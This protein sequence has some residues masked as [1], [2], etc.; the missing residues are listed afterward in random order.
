VN[1]IFNPEQTATFYDRPAET[2]RSINAANRNTNYSVVRPE[3]LDRI[4]N[5]L[6]HQR[7]RHESEHHW[8]HR[9]LPHRAVLAVA[10]PSSDTVRLELQRTP[11]SEP[12]RETVEYDLVVLATGYRHNGH[13]ELLAPL[14]KS[15]AATAERS[16]G[17]R[18]TVGKDYRLHVAGV[19]VSPDAGIWLQGCNEE[20]HGVSLPMT[21]W[22]FFEMRAKD[23]C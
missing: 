4:Y 17:E 2:R 23:G 6:Y 10:A 14:L 5:T 13:E 3:L 19:D 21:F 16:D 22:L 11:R 15:A 7:L 1:E 20:T 8:P 18:W 12:S 9:I